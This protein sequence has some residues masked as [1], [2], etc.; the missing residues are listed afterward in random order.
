MYSHVIY[1]S[2]KVEPFTSITFST[3]PL[4]LLQVFFRYSSDNKS[5]CFL[6]LRFRLP[7]V[8]CLLLQASFSKFA[9]MEKSRGLRSGLLGGQMFFR[10]TLPSPKTSAKYL[11]TGAEV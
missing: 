10:V 1:L 5:H 2:S 6:M 9:Q 3:R 7:M 8:M 11:W 4:K